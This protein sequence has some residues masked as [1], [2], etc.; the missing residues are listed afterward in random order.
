MKPP[1]PHSRIY[2][3]GVPWP[4]NAIE[5]A[6]V[7]PKIPPNTGNIARTCAAIGCPLHL[8]HPL[9]FDLTEKQVRRAGLD[10]WDSMD[11]RE[12]ADDEAF[13][14]AMEGKRV[15]LFTTAGQQRFTEVE[16]ELGDIL[17][18]GSETEGL[19]QTWLDRFPDSTVAIPIRPD[20]VR[21]LNLSVSVGIAAYE[22]LRQVSHLPAKEF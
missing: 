17:V 21:S 11:V 20:L 15:H 5:V 16:Y 14:S 1:K 7:E 6:L 3:M 18:F 9:G 2:S 19:N 4:E 13:F 22:A 10:Y 12:H 8:V